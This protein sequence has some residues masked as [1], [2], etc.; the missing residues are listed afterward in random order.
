M[1]VAQV[2]TTILDI[3]WH[4][5]VGQAVDTMVGVL[6]KHGVTIYDM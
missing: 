2:V 1:A 6:G 5:L 4:I 3:G